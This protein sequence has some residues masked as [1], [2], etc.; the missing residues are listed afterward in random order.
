MGAHWYYSRNACPTSSTVIVLERWVQG[1]VVV[2][3][4]RGQTTTAQGHVVGKVEWAVVSEGMA[5]GLV[6]GLAYQPSSTIVR[7][8]RV[9]MVV[10]WGNG[11]GLSDD[12][13]AVEDVGSELDGSKRWG[14]GGGSR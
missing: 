2:V 5:T 7:S 12:E 6:P 14:W 13:V 11:P 9:V 10:G 1:L 8:E 4:G 3:E